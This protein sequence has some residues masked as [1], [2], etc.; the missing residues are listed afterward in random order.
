[1][2]TR[3]VILFMFFIIAM[4]V[5]TAGCAEQKFSATA[6][7]EFSN[8]VDVRPE[9]KCKVSCEDSNTCF[10]NYDYSIDAQ[11]QITDI[12][13]VNDN[14]GSMYPEQ[15]EMGAR[16]PSLVERLSDV[17]YRIAVTTTDIRTTDLPYTGGKLLPF[18]NGLSFLDGSLPIAREQNYFQKVIQREETR[19]C[20]QNNYK[21]EFCA[22]GDERGIY[23]SALV[24]E[25]N[26]SD[27]IRPVGHL[28]IVVLSDED[29]ASTGEASKLVEIEKPAKFVEFFRQKYPNKSM[30]FHSII[31]RPEDAPGGLAC[32]NQ[33]KSNPNVPPGHYGNVYAELTKL[34]GGIL[35]NICSTPYTNQLKSIGDAV[36]QVREVLPCKPIGDVKVTYLPEPSV[37]VNYQI[38]SAQNEILFS[39]NLPKGT[40]IRFQFKCSEK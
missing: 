36:A 3:E 39:D 16:F 23:A 8:C 40:K 15:V 22:S 2:R 20:E 10:K 14:S 6:D 34:T 11:A 18:Q 30:K 33:Q 27:F 35:G 29:E 13:F 37:P 26:P 5:M 24:I 32:F 17:N 19:I 21:R 9:V 4:L 38:N 31:I 12:L 28:A 1:M 25:N 7:S